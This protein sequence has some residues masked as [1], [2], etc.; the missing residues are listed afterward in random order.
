M[1]KEVASFTECK[2]EQL[3]KFDQQKG[4]DLWGSFMRLRVVIDVSKP[5]PRALKIRTVLRDEH[6]VSFTYE[7]LPSFCYLC[8]RLGHI[9]KWCETRFN[10]G[11]IN[12]GDDSPFGPWLKAVVG[13][14]S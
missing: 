3:R 2:I 6:L 13:S 4:P 9:S 11:F 10:D 1:T 7:S 14:S 12:S 8:G 5:L